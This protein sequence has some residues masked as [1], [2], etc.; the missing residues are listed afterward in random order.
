MGKIDKILAQWAHGIK[1][2]NNNKRIVWNAISFTELIHNK[3]EKIF[4]FG[5]FMTFNIGLFIVII[6]FIK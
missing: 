3:Y 2:T 5:H 1:I 4:Q 6:L